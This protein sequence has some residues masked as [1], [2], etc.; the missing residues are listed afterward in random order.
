MGLE[1]IRLLASR[2][3]GWVIGTW[4][5]VAAL[6]GLLSPDLTRLAAEGQARML[7]GARRAAARPSWSG[8]AGPT[9]LTSR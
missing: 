3:P 2:R 1:V 9:S 5:I 6:V 8:S 7:A 4:L